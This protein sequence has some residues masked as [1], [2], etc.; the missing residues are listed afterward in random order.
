MK[1]TIVYVLAFLMLMVGV[2]ACVESF[3]D[4]D[5]TVLMKD[6]DTGNDLANFDWKYTLQTDGKHLFEY[7]VVGL[8]PETGVTSAA[9]S[10]KAEESGTVPGGDVD[11]LA[12]H[13]PDDSNIF[14]FATHLIAG[15]CTG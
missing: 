1:K 12:T 10:G 8:D 5:G 2:N 13:L 15:L 7:R 6:I 11:V 14:T 3:D 4:K 9:L